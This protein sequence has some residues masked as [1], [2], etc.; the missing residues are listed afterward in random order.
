MFAEAFLELWFAE[1]R[2]LTSTSSWMSWGRTRENPVVPSPQT[3][4]VEEARA[5][6]GQG[7]SSL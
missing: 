6:P 7:P 2:S 1:I 3:P 5:L 4:P